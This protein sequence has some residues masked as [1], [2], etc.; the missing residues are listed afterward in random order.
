VLI[1]PRKNAEEGEANRDEV[2]TVIVP[3]RNE[4]AAIEKC[5]GSILAQD[6]LARGD[7]IIFA[8]G[9]SED[10][11]MDILRRVAKLDPRV[12]VMSNPGRITSSGLNAAIGAS[13]G[14]IIVRLDAHTE[15][16]SDYIS[17]C[18]RALQATGAANVGGP[19]RTKTETY[20]EK[21][22]AAAYH[23]PFSVGGARF[24]D[25]SY[26]GF[27]DTVTYGC[28]P[29]S[30]FEKFGL[31]DEQLVRNQDDEHNLRITRQG[32]KV[33]QSA[34][35]KS[36]YRPRGTLAALFKQYMQYGYWKVRVIQKHKLPASFR[37]LVP[38]TFLLALLLLSLSS[39]LFVS[40][41]W[42]LLLL[43]GLYGLAVM[44]ASIQTARR[45]EWKLLPT[46][47][48]VF[49]CY[50]FAYGTGF[51]LGTWDFVIRRVQPRTSFSHLTR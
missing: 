9:L 42:L 16:A 35:I 45:S 51:L 17:Q 27:V 24:H 12:K 3:C 34:N 2:V 20:M 25:A 44:A 30:T 41:L 37:H 1:K 47:P 5:I 46:L 6:G 28:W 32:G 39:L 15:Y 31:F 26:E 29:R 14:N 38:G 19:A 33:Y 10:G 23:S 8:D 21:A 50:H 4:A 18:C 11:T 36:W 13:R 49:G 22:I 48:F 40:A 43:L 7:E